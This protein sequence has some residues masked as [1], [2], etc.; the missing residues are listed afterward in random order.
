[1]ARSDWIWLDEGYSKT[2]VPPALRLKPNQDSPMEFKSHCTSLQFPEMIEDS[3]HG[4]TAESSIWLW[5]SRSADAGTRSINHAELGSQ[6]PPLLSRPDS[7][8]LYWWHFQIGA[9]RVWSSPII[10]SA[11]Y[12]RWLSEISVGET[13]YSKHGVNCRKPAAFSSATYLTRATGREKLRIH[14]SAK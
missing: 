10:A 8:H 2:A 5:F 13:K 4:Q 12:Q 7:H 11:V 3:N 14:E 1:M 6:Q 9:P